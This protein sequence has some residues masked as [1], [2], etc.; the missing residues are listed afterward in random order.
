MTVPIIRR[1]DLTSD[2]QAFLNAWLFDDNAVIVPPIEPGQQEIA[3]WHGQFDNDGET[4]V[5]VRPISMRALNANKLSGWYYGIARENEIR[6]SNDTLNAFVDASQFF[7]GAS[8][9]ETLGVLACMAPHDRIQI[10]G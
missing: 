1:L 8:L 6:A 10:A 4:P 2:R 3:L 7:S 5:I 9:A